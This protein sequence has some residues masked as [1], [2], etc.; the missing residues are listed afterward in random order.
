MLKQY[1]GRLLS[2]VEP[3]TSNS[4]GSGMWALEEYMQGQA[5]GTWPSALQ[6]V[7][8]VFSTYLYTGN[9]STQTIATGIDLAGKGGMLWIKNRSSATNNIISDTVRGAGNFLMS[10]ASSQQFFNTDNVSALSSTGFSVGVDSNTNGT[11]GDKYAT[12]TFRKAP[13]FFDIVTWTGNGAA[14]REIIHN[15]GVEPGMVIVKRTD[16][17]ADWVVWQRSLS[18]PSKYLVLNST[19]S[20]ATGNSGP[21]GSFDGGYNTNA[22]SFTSTF[23]RVANDVRSNASGGTYIAY[24]FAHD[25]AADGIIQCGSFTTSANGRSTPI[26]LGWEPQLVLYKA[27]NVTSA[28]YIFDQMRGFFADQNGRELRPNS[29]ND[30]QSSDQLFVNATG[31]QMGTPAGTGGGEGNA[32]YIYMAIRRGP[33]KIPTLGTSVFAPIA[34]SAAVGTQLTTN[35]PVD[36]F[37]TNYRNDSS[38]Y[39]TNFTDRLRGM[40]SSNVYTGQKL[41]VS[42]SSNAETEDNSAVGYQFWNT[43]FLIGQQNNL[44]ST[45][46]YNFR[47]APGFFDVVCY[48]G[49]GSAR[50]ISHNL[51]VAPEL[52][53]IKA[54]SQ[55]A[56]WPTWN[57]A[58]IGSLNTTDAF[59]GPTTNYINSVTASS[60]EVN[61]PGNAN[62]DTSLS[63]VRYVSYLFA[64]VPGVSKVGSYTGN[65]GSQTIDCAFTTGARFVLIKRT[66][67]TGDWYVWDSARGIVAGNDPYLALNTTVAEVTSNDSVDTDNTGFVVNQVGASNIN[68]TSATY[69]YLAIA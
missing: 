63:G 35:F 30:E 67:S 13:K 46:Y 20:T 29:A 8:D 32:T 51:G 58:K 54:R 23:F 39:N 36:L 31:F 34:S 2:S 22:S 28:W 25:A 42:S 61:N 7:E 5:A 18:D 11:A 4:S 52:I 14:S 37:I 12:W 19:A 57:A 40:Q 44:L 68:V 16:T 6:F 55:S 26:N 62:F 49:T 17:T 1:K 60:F 21:W 69:I 43:G 33:M 59:F 38:I 9:G 15:L 66:D 27:A 41:L 45:I 48:S 56:F 65:G 64:S 10:N 3:I 53:I 50:T 24:L 47:R